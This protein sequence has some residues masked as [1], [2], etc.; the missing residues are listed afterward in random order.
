MHYQVQLFVP[1]IT[2]LPAAFTDM[3]LANGTSHSRGIA[4]L[5]PFFKGPNITL[6]PQAH[7]TIFAGF[8]NI[9]VIGCAFVRLRPLTTFELNHGRT[10]LPS[11]NGVYTAS[12]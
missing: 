6:F 3:F 5:L 7:S 1:I 10:L 2:Q 8:T 9:H 4:F 11:N 12:T